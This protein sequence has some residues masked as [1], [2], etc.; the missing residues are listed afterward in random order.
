MG[1]PGA[2]RPT[3]AKV[4]LGAAQALGQFGGDAAGAADPL[5][6]AIG[7]EKDDDVKKAMRAARKRIKPE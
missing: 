6:R 2:P 3:D 5:D 1:S 4:R 7:A